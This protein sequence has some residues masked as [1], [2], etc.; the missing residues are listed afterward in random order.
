[1]RRTTL[2]RLRALVLALALLCTLTL[3]VYAEDPVS[4]TPTPTPA[5]T[6]SAVTIDPSTPA[7]LDVGKNLTLTAS[8][9]YDTDA[10]SYDAKLDRTVTWTSAS[11]SIA[12]VDDKGVVSAVAPGK[13]KITA[14]SNANKE[15]SAKCEVTVS[16]ITLSKT[17]LTLLVGRTESLT[18][19][20]FGTAA[21]K[22]IV[23]TT[24][25][26]SV[27]EVFG[28][29]ISAHYEGTA[30]IT[31]TANGTGYT[32]E[33]SVTVKKDEAEAI[34]SSVDGT[35]P[36]AFS[37][38]LSTLRSRC[39]EKTG[40][41]L[42][43]LSSISVSPKQG[44]LY[45]GYVSADAPGH[46][47]G[48][49]EKYYYAPG[50]GQEGI[51]DISFVAASDFNGTAEIAYTGYA[52]NGGS[53]HGTILVNVSGDSDVTYTAS[54]GR[55]LTF[56]S[57]EFIAVCQSR[58][59]RSISYL[60]F[61]QPRSYQGALYYD[62]STAA[63]FSQQV[64]SDT[65]YYV[66]SS[67]SL[68]RI[69]FV[70]ADGFTGTVTV[71]YRCTDSSGGT[72]NGRVTIRVSAANGSTGSTDVSYTTSVG[73]S[74]SFKPKDFNAASI[75]Y[76]GTSLDYVKF[77]L[78]AASEGVLYY[79]YTDSGSY[80]S[81]VGS[82]TR[83]YRS[84]S[85]PRIS[86]ITFVPAAGF[87]GT[88]TIPYT[89]YQDSGSFTGRVVIRV[90]GDDGVVSYTTTRGKTVYF[91][92]ADFNDLCRRDRGRS[93]SRI[94]FD[95]PSSS[96]GT[97][98]Y[99]YDSAYSSSKVSASTNYYRSD[100]P[101][102][103]DVCFVPASGFTGVVS[104]PFS[105]YDDGGSRW[106]GTVRIAVDSAYGA[107]VVRYSVPQ[108]GYIRF[109]ADDFNDAC[110]SIVGERLSYVRFEQPSAR[111]G[112]LYSQY[113]AYGKGN[114][115]LSSSVNCYRSGSGRLIDDVT[116]AAAT[117]FSG[118]VTIDYTGRSTN[119]RTYTGTVEITVGTS[120]SAPG[121]PLP[122]SD[123]SPTDYY[124]EPIRWAVYNGIA[125]GVSQTRFGVNEPC[126]RGQIVTYLWRAAGSP[127]PRS[128]GSPFVDVLPGSQ[129][130]QAVLWAFERGITSGTGA[131]T[132]SPEMTVSR[133]QAMTYLHR[134]AG[135]VSSSYSMSFSDVSNDAY[136]A[137]AIRWALS[138]GITS[139][140]SATTFSPNAPCTRAQIVTFLYRASLR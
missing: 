2:M 54:A 121:F 104:I 44:V 89:G 57:E 124:Y 130:Y 106:S 95:L 137:P 55:A 113:S 3:P 114:V 125:E 68:D 28:G 51:S 59:G 48:G 66:T 46:G 117:G 40:G 122:F 94:R 75:D 98:Y 140:T 9:T 72:Y 108:N 100:S 50:S 58:T 16:G 47:V 111:R 6:V 23:W 88:V 126:S 81:R 32:A 20:A 29:S 138:R 43:Y 17:S 33:C 109:D 110:R 74:V 80:S 14:V 52:S 61:D 24:S 82:T 53:F 56:T 21:D 102:V 87:S 22:G 139:G 103:S 60:T 67:P 45:Y 78:P 25:N 83:Y 120:A 136:Y 11:P 8:V 71:P 73:R 90:S 65:R 5:P 30:T 133:A 1:M 62:Y 115:E 38:F 70:P 84:G 26:P 116:F 31:A 41:S 19:S 105:G 92:A 79:N 107:E 12:T 123:V 135:L 27:A 4:P 96:Q 39:T 119:G 127:A 131:N 36:L 34:R 13:A 99:N 42:S 69:S 134:S 97:L 93:F 64:S 101:G 112:T 18:Y 86:G 49:S 128:T 132:F 85:S 129:Y 10:S 63:P 118:T 76:N 37:S 91:E 77:D 15:K 7:A 35:E